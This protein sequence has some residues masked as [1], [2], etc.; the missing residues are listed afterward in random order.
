MTVELRKNDACFV[1]GKNNAAGLHADF[2]V[3]IADRSI[4]GT[5]RPRPEHVGW[6]D[7]VHGGII[8]SLLDEAMVKLAAHLGMPAV[9]AEMTIRYK[10]AATPGDEIMVRGR[11]V[12]SRNRLIL[13]EASAGRGT[14]VIAEARGKLLK[15]RNGD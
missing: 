5:F 3:D 10:A 7:I 2:E 6:Q 14:T 8:A 15:V 12:D 13:V 11:I 1:C 4:R 9:S